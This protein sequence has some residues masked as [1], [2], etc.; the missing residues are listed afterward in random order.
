ME[1]KI[2]RFKICLIRILEGKFKE[3]RKQVL[4]EA[5]IIIFLELMK[6]MNLIKYILRWIKKFINCYFKVEI[7]RF[8]F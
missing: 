7:V 3:N 8:N 2:K 6:G 4:F 5:I 1:D